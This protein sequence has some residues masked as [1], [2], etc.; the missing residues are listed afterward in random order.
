[1]LLVYR[2]QPTKGNDIMLF[3]TF[4]MIFFF[5]S[6][7]IAAAL[8]ILSYESGFV[9]AAEP[10]I[11]IIKGTQNSITPAIQNERRNIG[12]FFKKLRTEKPVTIAYIGGSLTSGAGSSN[13]DKNS[14]RALV[15]E[16]LAKNFTKSKISE[17]N[18]GVAYTGSLYAALRAR[19]DVIADKPDLVFVDLTTSDGAEDETTVKKAVEGLLRQ[20]LI[21]SQPPEIVMIYAATP[22]Q[23]TR[24]EWYDVIA[25]HYQ[26]PT[27]NLQ[28]R[29]RA[30]IDAG[31]FKPSEIWKNG[32]TPSDFGHKLFAEQITAFLTEQ[33]SMEPTP[34]SRNLPIPLVSD[35][36]NY[37]EFR[38]F[39]EVKHETAWR[40]EPI[41]DRFFPTELLTTNKTGA[42]I[43]LYF[44]GTVVGLSF[45][46][47]PDAGII[48]C[49]IDGKQAP[50]PLNHI[51]C[52][53]STHHISTRIV[54]G[55]LGLGEHKLT[56]RVLPGRN[57]RSSGSNVRLGY[58]LFGG[59]RPERL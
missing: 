35:E 28:T 49:L 59:T 15:T 18:A 50:A 41:N 43:E 24:I 46:S 37:G 10:R 47:G 1:L 38:T 12:M 25:A 21:V 33:S 27:I 26:I 42:Q 44:E 53:D 57:A 29:V 39:A 4:K 5:P 58:L 54:A 8:S 7:I 9:A 36:L 56:I 34:I 13:P 52:Y 51:D 40:A 19:R 3:Q 45:R 14:Y 6:L 11:P 17:I 55:G 2:W 20:L 22:K 31:K 48:E 30:M 32:A 23:E 16:W